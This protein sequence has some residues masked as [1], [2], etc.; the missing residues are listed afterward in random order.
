MAAPA[1]KPS[2]DEARIIAYIRWRAT[3]N[4]N[5]DS[6]I[7]LELLADDLDKGEHHGD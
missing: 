4:C 1:R 7:T 5:V 2:D 6:S 3:T